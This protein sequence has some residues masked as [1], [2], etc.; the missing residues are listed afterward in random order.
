MK[1]AFLLMPFLFVG[2]AHKVVNR[3]PST[4]LMNTDKPQN[5][6]MGELE[7]LLKENKYEIR[8]FDAQ[9]GILVSKPRL[10]GYT[11]D[12]QKERARHTVQIRQEGG[13]VSMRIV[14]ECE[15][16]DKKGQVEYA[17]CPENDEGLT[18]KARKIE[19]LLV[20][21]IRQKVDK[22]AEVEKTKSF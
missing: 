3:E 2:C 5:L 16:T 15:Y 19:S 17:E 14:Y 6:L 20:R 22:A 12:G 9:T 7:G 11:V 1:Y 10:F 21:L 18:E 4:Y 13:S 8:T